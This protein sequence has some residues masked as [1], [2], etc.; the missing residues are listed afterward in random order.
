MEDV[1]FVHFQR[2]IYHGDGLA[3][4]VPTPKVDKGRYQYTSNCDRCTENEKLHICIT[5]TTKLGFGLMC[6]RV[7]AELDNIS[8]QKCPKSGK[9]VVFIPCFPVS[10]QGAVIVVIC[11]ETKCVLDLDQSSQT[12]TA[13][14]LPNTC[15]LT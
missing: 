6:G 2:V 5:N 14:S 13:T 12:L 4:C 1:K 3:T 7:L 15:Y 9:K 8:I 10:V 11:Q